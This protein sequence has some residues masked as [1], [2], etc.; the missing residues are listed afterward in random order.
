MLSLCYHAVS[1]DW[2]AALSVTPDNLERQI[3][4]LLGRGYRAATFTDA[5]QRGGDKTMA[6]TFDDSYRSVIELG[7]PILARLGVPATVF[8]PTRW[9]G[10]EEPMDW[11]GID[12]WLGGEHESELVPMSAEELER[13]VG[14]GWEV[15]SH[16][17]SHPRL[18]EIDDE[19]LER[20]LTESRR[21]CEDQLGA[22]CTSLAYPYGDHDERVAAATARA[23]YLAAGTL[24]SPMVDTAAL[25]WPRVGVYH[26]D[27]FLRFR[28]KVSPAVQ[29]FRASGP[30]RW[31]ER[32]LAR[33]R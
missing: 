25:R 27:D 31:A 12:R 16:T 17:V 4:H 9:L 15:G 3:R 13:L 22:P 32:Q 21:V 30:V 19:S 7:L 6:I 11:P 24:P 33:L 5:V 18:T 10:A 1:P 14:A 23:G 28:A 29:G 8:V 26:D 20:E 2:P